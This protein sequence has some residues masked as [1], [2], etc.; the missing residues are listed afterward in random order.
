MRGR[1]GVEELSDS[2]DECN[3][4]IHGEPARALE[5]ARAAR[6]KLAELKGSVSTYKFLSLR[7]RADGVFATALHATGRS[8]QALKVFARAR[9]VRS[10]APVERATLALRLARFHADR[11]EWEDALREAN[12]A[13]LYFACHPPR[14]AVD[15]R[16]HATALVYRSNVLKDAYAAGVSLPGIADPAVEAEAGY[17]KALKECTEGTPKTA[18]MALINLNSLALSTWWQGPDGR[19]RIKP[20]KVVAAMTT[21]CRSLAHQ[22]FGRKSR[23]H[24][25]ARWIMAIAI[26]EIF[27]WLNRPAE[28]KLLNAMDDLLELGA[29][30]DA[31]RLCLDMC[32]LYYR[33]S[34]WD[35]MAIVTATV[36]QHAQ[37]RGLPKSWY[38]ALLLW[39]VAIEKGE[40]EKVF[41]DVFEKIRGFR[42]R[43]PRH[44]APS[45][46]VHLPRQ[47]Y[48]DRE[49][50]GGL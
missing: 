5:A 32:H 3:D 48:G 16:A 47:R 20:A 39:Q 14:P 23:P 9:R 30:D 11:L 4:L 17:R 44:A 15:G 34:R 41:I 19:R 13:E 49:D 46:D 26:A 18:L 27:G 28:Q 6:E 2:L 40:T 38:D 50:T 7:V 25:Y 12:F 33:E 1:V 29:L 43:L 31:A 22:E 8:D 42:I 37:A 24:A 10:A 45:G 21:V 35:D 36:L